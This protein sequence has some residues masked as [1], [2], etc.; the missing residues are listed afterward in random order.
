MKFTKG[1]WMYREGITASHIGQ[2]RDVRKEG[3]RICLYSVPYVADVRRIGGPAIEIHLSS[4][5]PNII[6]V[7]AYHFLGSHRKMPNFELNDANVSPVVEDTVESLTFTSGDL[8]LA[9]TKRPC[10]FTFYYKGKKLAKVERNQE[11]LSMISTIRA[12][13][14]DYMR[15]Q[16]DLDFVNIH[17]A[18]TKTNSYMAV[19]MGV[20]LGEKIYGFGER[21]TP[22]V[23]NGQAVNTWN[24]DGG[25][26]T[27][28]AYKSIPFYISNRGYG[29]LVNDAGPVSYEVCSEAVT[30]VQ[31]SVPGEKIDFMVIGG[32]DMKGVLSSYTTLTG[33][34]ALPPAWSFGLWLSSSFT[35]KY[36][37]ETVMHFVNGMKERH[38]PLRVFHFDCFW[39]RENE[40]C[41]FR[42]DSQMFPDI[43]GQLR[44]MREEHG[45]KICVWINPYIGQKSPLFREAMDAGYLLKKDNGD[46][47]QWDLWQ[48]GLA[49]V[50]FTNPDAWRWYQNK[51]ETLL[52]QGVDCMKTDF[53]ERVPTNV[54]YFDGSDPLRMHNMYTY[55]YNKC[56]FEVIKRVKGENEALVFARS[57]TVGGQKFPVHWG[58]DCDSKYLSMA[59]SLRGGLSLCMSGFGFWSHDISGFEGTATADLYK[60]WTAFGLLSTHSRL[61]GSRSYRVPWLFSKEGEQNGEESVAV[62]RH[63]CE[64]KCRLMPYIFASAVHTHNTGVPLMRAMVLEF[65]EDICCEDLDRQYMFGERLLVAPV[66]TKEG[67]VTYYLPEGEWTHLLSGEMKQGGKWIKETYDFFSLPL[68]VRENTILPFGSNAQMPDYDYTDGLTLQIYNLKDSAETVVCNTEGE[69]V[70]CVTATRN[71]DAV[72]VNLNG[73]YRDTKL[74]LVNVSTVRDVVGARVEKTDRDIFLCVEKDEIS[75]TI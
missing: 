4:P 25:T 14:E 61:H 36:D 23:K 8:S 21:F 43:D 10:D 51:L 45:L 6:R 48:S 47:W 3:D 58:G 69:E 31:F 15:Q 27:E 17:S 13:D 26:N 65:P 34:P 37:E 38:I 59:E 70:L 32:D 52:R 39:M 5:Q 44:R 63:F 75:F 49:L 11:G 54:T 56:V 1:R 50:D 40:W 7:E 20:D 18:A 28:L 72:T 74:Q 57:A 33:K 2:I 53:G 71:G 29:V 42:W 35:T 55:L 46:V 60:R 67:D 68:F 73:Q 22:F 9:V 30:G 41:N 19:R 16:M 66:F 64:L 12:L 24:D 62:L